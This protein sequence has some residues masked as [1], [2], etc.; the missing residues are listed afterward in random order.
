MRAQHRVYSIRENRDY[1]SMCARAP[2]SGSVQLQAASIA[3]TE[4][5]TR[6]PV[7]AAPRDLCTR[8]FGSGLCSAIAMRH[9]AMFLAKERGTILSA[10]VALSIA[11]FS[12]VIGVLVRSDRHKRARTHC[13]VLGRS[14]TT[15]THI[16]VLSA[17]ARAITF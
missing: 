15:H 16:H 3:R 14:S 11:C 8:A 6:L 2:F 1:K 4:R 10:H 17:R 5:A 13:W 12:F 9:G 7:S